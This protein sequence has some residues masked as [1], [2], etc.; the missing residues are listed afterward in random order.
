MTWGDAI[1]QA[2]KDFFAKMIDILKEFKETGAH[3]DEILGREF[4]IFKGYAPEGHPHPEAFTKGKKPEKIFQGEGHK[5]S[6]G[7]SSSNL[8]EME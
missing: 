7:A 2:D 6:E 1:V 5:L 3:Y 8:D 4:P